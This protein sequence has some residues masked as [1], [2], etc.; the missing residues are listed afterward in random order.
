MAGT[1]AARTVA[2][3]AWGCRARAS[4]SR[5]CQ[6][7]PQAFPH[8]ARQQPARCCPWTHGPRYGQQASLA[9]SRIDFVIPQVQVPTL[10]PPPLRHPTTVHPQFAAIYQYR[11]A[12]RLRHGAAGGVGDSVQRGPGSEVQGRGSTMICGP[13][14]NRGFWSPAAAGPRCDAPAQTRLKSLA[15][16]AGQQACLS[17]KNGCVLAVIKIERCNPTWGWRRA[18]KAT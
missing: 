10:P 4:P 13:A 2:G 16:P 1:T 14:G 17:K 5:Q 6:M 9:T 3:S 11:R 18:V 8:P 12:R 7:C 15:K